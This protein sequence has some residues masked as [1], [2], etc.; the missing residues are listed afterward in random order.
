[1]TENDL[2]QKLSE[3]HRS[4]R[5]VPEPVTGEKLV[6]DQLANDLTGL[7]SF[8]YPLEEEIKFYEWEKKKYLLNTRK[9]F[10]SE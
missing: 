9:K 1:M 7:N 3:T 4:A 5:T 10:E 2:H 6:F 8:S